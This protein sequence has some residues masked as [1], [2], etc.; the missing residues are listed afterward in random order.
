M[1]SKTGDSTKQKLAVQAAV[2]G[3]R[4]LRTEF[5]GGV[6]G[7]MIVVAEDGFLRRLGS[8]GAC[9]DPGAVEVVVEE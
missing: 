6:A 4:E 1:R 9:R 8:V 5:D 7:H 3:E 2:G